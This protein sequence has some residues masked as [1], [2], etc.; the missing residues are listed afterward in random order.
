MCFGDQEVD[1]RLDHFF[2]SHTRAFWFFRY[3]T[4][5]DFV[6]GEFK[7]DSLRRTGSTIVEV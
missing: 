2:Q 5:D 6:D 1:G 4:V 3:S 7:Y